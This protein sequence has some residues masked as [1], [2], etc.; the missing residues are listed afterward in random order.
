MRST[1]FLLPLLVIMA[2]VFS[3]PLSHSL[4][5]KAVPVLKDVAP[6]PEKVDRR[7]FPA[8]EN[9]IEVVPI[10]RRIAP[11]VGDQQVDPVGVNT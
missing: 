11:A 7:H 9:S 1:A 8:L 2:G 3:A 5:P 4:G 6:N 10:D